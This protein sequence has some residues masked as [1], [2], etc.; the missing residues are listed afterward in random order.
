MKFKVGDRVKIVREEYG[1]CTNNSN[2]SVGE[3]FVIEEIIEDVDG[4]CWCREH[5]GVS[6]GVHENLL[7]LVGSYY[8]STDSM[9]LPSYNDNFLQGIINNSFKSILNRVPG[10]QNKPETKKMLN[11]FMKKLLDKNTKTL[12]E[13]EFINGDLLPTSYGMEALNSILFEANKEALVKLAE[14]VIAEIK[15]K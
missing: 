12:I 8:C 1:E 3:E 9:F 5:W 7:E 4:D 15:D 2:R 6:T 14:E 11:H 10:E 13:A